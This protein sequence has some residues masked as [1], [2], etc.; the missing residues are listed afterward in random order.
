MKSIYRKY[1]TTVALIWTGCFVL[2]FFVYMLVLAPQK[3]TK[4]QVEEQL[5]EKEQIYNSAQKAQQE[6][7]KIRLNEQI[8]RLRNSLK[9]FVID[10]EDSANLIFDIRQI[11]SEKEVASFSVRTKN[12]RAG[13]AIP[14]CNYI[15]EN[16][17]EI[18]FN[19]DFNQF[20]A[21][22]NALERH[23]PVVFVDRFTITRSDRDDSGHEVD[24][25]LAVFVRKRQDS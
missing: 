14:N 24:M 10:F 19:A 2:L 1:F 21:L 3:N 25:K 13:S 23:Q 20:A 16:H 8:E 5:A 18:S 9:E 15:C 11:A 7:T 17:V 12:D 4:K 22:L 6:E